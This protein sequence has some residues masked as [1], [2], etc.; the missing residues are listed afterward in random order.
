MVA[1][2]IPTARAA[3][4]AEGRQR[5][6][7]LAPRGD[8]TRHA[9][10]GE[11]MNLRAGR[12]GTSEPIG[13]TCVVRATVHIGRD[14]VRRVLNEERLGMGQAASDGDAILSRI[15]Q[16]EN[17]MPKA[18][19]EREQL[20]IDLGHEDWADLFADVGRT[21][22]GKGQLKGGVYVRE[23]IGWRLG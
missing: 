14:G 17:G 22:N 20:A 11:S 10:V 21:A 6:L 16:A 23:L 9:F 8:R 19:A 18:A 4:V 1:Y 5:F 2:V 7:L 12:P 15:V 13:A 3:A